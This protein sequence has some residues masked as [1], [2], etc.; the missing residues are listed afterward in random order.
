MKNNIFNNF[1]DYKEVADEIKRNPGLLSSACYDM[2]DDEYVVH[3]VLDIDGLAL[4]HASE[5]LRDNDLTVA[6]AIMNNP[7]A[8]KYA[9]ERIKS[10]PSRIEELQG[11]IKEWDIED[12]AATVSSMYEV[13]FISRQNGMDWIAGHM[14]Q[15]GDCEDDAI[16][17]AKLYVVNEYTRVRCKKC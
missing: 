16:E 6:L 14:F 2:R 3:A 1:D 15:E 10:D 7:G 12:D 9:S 13:T 4:Q 8:F 11:N 17:S 5:H